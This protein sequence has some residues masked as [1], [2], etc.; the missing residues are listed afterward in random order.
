MKDRHVAKRSKKERKRKG[1]LV[2]VG[3]NQIESKGKEKVEMKQ[4]LMCGKENKEMRFV[5]NYLN[6]PS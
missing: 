3:K 2:L 1:E 5:F 4:V 6:I